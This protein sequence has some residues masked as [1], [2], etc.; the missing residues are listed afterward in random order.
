MGQLLSNAEGVRCSKDKALKTAWRISDSDNVDRTIIIREKTETKHFGE[1]IDR[2]T[3]HT[4]LTALTI[5][6][7]L[8]IIGCTYICWLI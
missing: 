2:W 3:R 5:A 7:L 6:C 1:V 8:V 4:E